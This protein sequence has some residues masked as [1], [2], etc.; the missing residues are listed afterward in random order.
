MKKRKIIYVDS[1]RDIPDYKQKGID[2]GLVGYHDP[3][4]DKIYMV[5]G[6]GG[7]SDVLH[8]TYHSIKK[9]PEKPRSPTRFIENEIEADLYAYRKSRQPVHIKRTL[10]GLYWILTGEYTL[11]HKKAL[12]IIT[13]IMKRKDIPKTWKQDWLDILRSI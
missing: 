5:K 12:S 3:K 1:F 9:H 8:E 2:S 4:T 6:K 11:K 10:A 13:N 7:K